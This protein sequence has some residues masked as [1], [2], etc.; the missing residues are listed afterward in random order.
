MPAVEPPAIIED[1]PRMAP[2]LS[3]EVETPNYRETTRKFLLDFMRSKGQSTFLT[4]KY[5]IES[6]EHELRR[7]ATLEANWDSYGAE[8]PSTLAIHAARL[9][10][11]ELAN[12]L[13]SPSAIV[14]SAGGGVS[15]YFFNDP[16]TAYIENDNAGEQALVMYDRDGNTEVLEIGTDLETSEVASRLSR[17]L[18]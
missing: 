18:G 12:S 14:A 1:A 16:R 11:S 6:A 17:Y 5:G 4:I 7:M 9:I 3:H 8:P 2:S 13:I 10:I 15:I